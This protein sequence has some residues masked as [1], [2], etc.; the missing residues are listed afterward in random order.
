MHFPARI[1]SAKKGFA[2]LEWMFE[3]V[4]WPKSHGAQPSRSFQRTIQECVAAR[5]KVK[6]ESRW[7]KVC[8]LMF[9]AQY[10]ETHVFYC[11]SFLTLF[12]RFASLK[13]PSKGGTR[14]RP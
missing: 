9:A 2:S 10:F 14:I 5:T 11:S 6:A 12:C 1:L 4:N 8:V 7:L 3:F 13:T